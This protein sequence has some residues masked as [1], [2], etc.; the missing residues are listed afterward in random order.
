MLILVGTG[1]TGMGTLGVDHIRRGFI[2]VHATTLGVVVL[3]SSHSLFVLTFCAVAPPEPPKS[4]AL[5]QSTSM[6]RF[7]KGGQLLSTSRKTIDD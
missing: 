4:F 5:V 2:F 3:H 7:R 1:E 6:G